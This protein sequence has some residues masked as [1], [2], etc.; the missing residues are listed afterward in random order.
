MYKT[1]KSLRSV[2]KWIQSSRKHKRRSVSI[3]KRRINSHQILILGK[4]HQT[5]KKRRKQ[6]TRSSGV[7]SVRLGRPK[8]K[9]EKL[10]GEKRRKRRRRKRLR[11]WR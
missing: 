8:R 6:R 5:E 7:S 4:R 10:I 2:L 11:S 9:L 1:K 3:T